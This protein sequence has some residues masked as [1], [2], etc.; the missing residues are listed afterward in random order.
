MKHF[1]IAL[2]CLLVTSIQALAQQTTLFNR[3]GDA[4]AYIDEQKDQTI[5]LWDG[6]PVAFLIKERNDFLIV[7]FNRQVLGWYV[8]GV[9][10]DSKGAIIGGRKD[11]LSIYTRIEGMKSLQKMVP[12]KPIAP[13]TPVQ[14][15]LK[16][17]WSSQELGELLSSGKK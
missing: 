4:I 14:P 6:T 15:I 5:F 3:S 16:R 12:I 1:F 10:Y 7:G 9:V 17:S 13:L 8:N 11:A 2:T